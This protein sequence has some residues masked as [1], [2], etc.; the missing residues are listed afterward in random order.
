MGILRAHTG[1]RYRG[2]K[3]KEAALAHNL[4]VWNAIYTEGNMMSCVS[5][6]LEEHL[7][8]TWNSVSNLMREVRVATNH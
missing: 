3:L 5:G 8:N 1:G 4:L 6:R 7:A 2:V